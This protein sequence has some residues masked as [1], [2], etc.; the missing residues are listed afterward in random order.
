M[1]SLHQIIKYIDSI[2]WG[3]YFLI[4]LLLGTGLFFTLR[5]IFIQLRGLPH[6]LGL[7]SG[8]YDKADDPGDVTH[9][10]ALSA[11]LSATIGIGNIAGVATAIHL[12]GPGAVFWMWVT[13][14]FGMPLKYA[15]ITL[16]HKFRTIN[17]D[18]TVSGGAMY[19][20]E[21]GLGKKWK[22]LAIMFAFCGALAAF[23][24]GNM[25]QSNTVAKTLEQSFNI[26]PVLVGAIL[27]ILLGLVIVGG[28]RRIAQVTS[29]L[30]PFMCIVYCLG[31]LVVLALHLTAI[32]AA[33]ALIV[34]HAFT[35]TAAAGG[36][37][38]AVVMT[39]LR[40]G[41]A[42]GLFSNESGLGSASIAHAAAKTK[43]PVREGL[44]GMVGPVIDTLIIC[45]MTALVII[46]TGAWTTSLD[47]A[48]LTAEGFKRGL[49]SIGF[50]NGGL[51]VSIG[52]TLF[53][54]STAITWSYYG[55]RCIQYLLG[56]KAVKPYRYIYI[57]FYFLGAIFALEL[58]WDLA[59]LANGLMA[60]PNLLGLLLMSPLL[61]KLTK[62]YFRRRQ[63]K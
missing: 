20:I 17:S 25:V 53:A 52:V 19:Y 34:K 3:P 22:P 2:V 36:F 13:A 60:L 4:P 39:T 43:E 47:G 10:Q 6:A 46:L 38:G 42:R 8:K 41:V 49:A 55:D 50:F 62:D 57:I 51:I 12:G 9:F 29:K 54:F 63:Q 35:P 44:V 32:P 58:V 27:A 48:S 33:L 31:A 61:V 16:S 1:E 59:D 5:L 30:V 14:F 45:T 28:I 21:R 23:G 11:A 24:I 7:L 40:Y 15:G 37:A 56:P 18:G 26:S